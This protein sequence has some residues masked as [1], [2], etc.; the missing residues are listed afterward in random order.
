MAPF[1][2]AIPVLSMNI[3]ARGHRFG[4]PN[5]L[6]RHFHGPVRFPGSNWQWW[7]AD[8]ERALSAA[9][10]MDAF[11][12]DAQ[13]SQGVHTLRT[14]KG[15][16]I[17]RL[18]DSAG[19]FFA[20]RIPLL[21]LRKRIGA[22]TGHQNAL[23]G[24]DHGSAEVNNTLFLNEKTGYGLPV[25][26]LGE[27]QQHGLPLQQLLIQPWLGDSVGLKTLWQT[28]T[29]EHRRRLLPHIEKVLT[30]LHDARLL[31]M[32][33]HGGNI[34]IDENDVTPG[35]HVIDCDKMAIHVAHPQLATALHVGK[36][37]RELE[38]RHPKDFSR[39]LT[40][41]YS[42]QSRITGADQ[43]DEE[44]KTL[45]AISLRYRMSK[46]IS[47]RRLVMASDGSVERKGLEARAR[48]TYKNADMPPI[49]WSQLPSSNQEPDGIL[50][51]PY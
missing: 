8:E 50:S 41:A 1:Q 42:M 26:C 5:V 49:D 47:R 22:L 4:R 51:A 45:L 32:D 37:L 11:L 25:Y 29:P 16:S 20:K 38:G 3:S 7:V 14:F 10:R 31:H 6:Q 12:K 19:D 13:K 44:V 28:A 27:Y 24:F 15:R 9:C 34:M 46:T 23:L 18:H 35:L 48:R 30:A 43:L 36:L 33:L 17:Y 21:T 2:G 40:L 39:L